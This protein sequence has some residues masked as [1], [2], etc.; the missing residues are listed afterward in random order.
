VNPYNLLDIPLSSG[1]A[2]ELIIAVSIVIVILVDLCRLMQIMICLF[3]DRLTIWGS[4][5]MRTI[6]V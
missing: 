1:Y 6:L 2:S 5:S 4:A 3:V